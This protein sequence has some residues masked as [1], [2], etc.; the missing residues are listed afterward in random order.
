MHFLASQS[1]LSANNDFQDST[2]MQCGCASVPLVTCR[3]QEAE[4]KFLLVTLESLVKNS[5]VLSYCARLCS[6]TNFTRRTASVETTLNVGRDAQASRGIVNQPVK[7]AGAAVEQAVSV[8]ASHSETNVCS[9]VRC[10]VPSCHCDGLA[11]SWCLLFLLILFS[12]LVKGQYLLSNA[13]LLGVG[14]YSDQLFFI[15]FLTWPQ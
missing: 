1:L 9:D 15:F 14:F 6:R 12:L 3:V 10:C 8:E 4:H 2:Y 11:G 13:S 7:S 5:L